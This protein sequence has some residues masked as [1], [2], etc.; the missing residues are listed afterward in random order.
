[1]KLALVER[2]K[3]GKKRIYGF[4]TA[5]S[6]KPEEIEEYYRSRWGTETNNRKRNEFRATTTSRS[7][8][9]RCLYYMLSVVMHNIWILVN[10][11]VAYEVYRIHA[12]PLIETY[13]LKELVLA[14]LCT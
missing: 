13:L 12:A 9:L 4:V 3:Y 14:E 10:L 2:E 1:M 6:W 5:L 8:E 7:F 11:M